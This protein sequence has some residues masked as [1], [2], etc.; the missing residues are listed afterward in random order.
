MSDGDAMMIRYFGEKWKCSFDS[1]VKHPC[2]IS[3]LDDSL[4]R[5][6]L[7]NL[8]SWHHQDHSGPFHLRLESDFNYAVLLVKHFRLSPRNKSNEKSKPSTK[9]SLS[10]VGPIENYLKLIMS[11]IFGCF[12]HRHRLLG[13][14][15]KTNWRGPKPESKPIIWPGPSSKDSF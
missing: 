8:Y 10:V 5:L 9:I 6:P 12:S 13:N 4:W 2:Q 14:R 15:R 3:V 7:S 1:I 11:T